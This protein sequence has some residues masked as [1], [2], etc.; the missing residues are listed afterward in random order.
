MKKY[1][2]FDLDGTLVNT[3][4]DLANATNFVLGVFGR[5]EKWCIDDYKEF[6]G[7]G[8]KKLL[9]RAFENTLLSHEL[10]K[11]YDI[12]KEEYLKIMLNN[13]KPYDGIS[14]VL[15]C[16]KKANIK[17]AVITN[18]PHE[19]AQKMVDKTF[20]SE[21]FDLVVGAAEGLPKKPNPA[22]VLYA[23][24]T[25]GAEKDETVF[26]GDSN[27]DI[28]TARSAKIESV[29]CSWGFRSFEELLF[30]KPSAIISHPKYILNFF[31]K[32]VDNGAMDLV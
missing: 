6:V 4:D 9:E 21:C 12:F 23:L 11:A 3:I 29:G 1:A 17:M 13:A 25:L 15:N 19:A 32:G 14:N 10:E 22:G 26:F 31:E 7:D 27:V 5:D 28:I 18:K 8:A 2:F 16:L 20:G 30:E 24:K